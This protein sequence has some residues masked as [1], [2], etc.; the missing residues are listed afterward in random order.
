M[1]LSSGFRG[2]Q[3]R[4]SLTMA[5][6]VRGGLNAPHIVQESAD[7]ST[8]LSLVACGVGIAIVSGASQWRH[9]PGVSLDLTRKSGLRHTQAFGGAPVMLL[10][11][12]GH[13]IP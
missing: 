7:E 3:A 4:C 9:P 8:L 6:C 10:F 5:E 1:F 12:N 13:E 11:P 2:G